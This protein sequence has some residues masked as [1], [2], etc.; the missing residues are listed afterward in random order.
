MHSMF[1]YFFASF[2]AWLARANL[3][4]QGVPAIPVCEPGT[5]LLRG[6]ASSTPCH[7]SYAASHLQRCTLWL[8]STSLFLEAWNK[9]VDNEAN[10]WWSLE[11]CLFAVGAWTIFL[12]TQRRRLG[13]PQL[14][15]YMLLGQTV[16]ISFAACLFNVALALRP[17]PEGSLVQTAALRS[18][19][20]D[21]ALPGQVLEVQEEVITEEA[22][23][24]D[25]TASGVV[26]SQTVKRKTTSQYII[27]AP[28][29]HPSLAS[30]LLLWSLTL[31]AAV[32]LK[33]RP[34][35]TLSVAI[36][37]LLPLA[38]TL[39]H[40]WLHRLEENIEHRLLR[41]KAGDEDEAGIHASNA[42]LQSILRPSSLLAVLAGWGF[43]MKAWTT[44]A[45]SRTLTTSVSAYDRVHLGR[46]T[47]LR[48]IIYPITF[49]SHPAQSSISSDAVCLALFTA[50]FIALDAYHLP[51][52]VARLG[53]PPS[54]ETRLQKKGPATTT[55]PARLSFT[56]HH[57]FA[58]WYAPSILLILMTPVLGPMTTFPA[59]LSLRERQLEK[60]ELEDE[61]R[62]RG[63]AGEGIGLVVKETREEI[64][65]TRPALKK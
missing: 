14:W 43:L 48:N 36:M 49:H 30:R 44:I 63:E 26:M 2:Q 65:S 60:A 16:A 35:T 64:V 54:E 24:E 57:L 15:A 45:L 22:Q 9:V 52:S 7:I 10:Y 38:L 8:S 50:L 6:L 47:L 42:R 61:R 1:R 51:K 56:Q 39:P 62:L 28:S 18:S 33:D 37:H 4:S 12:Q 32:S 31:L 3:T 53:T 27:E 29:T 20:A 34:T 13:V 19:S 55:I 58:G 41:P 25:G 46:A 11:V 21:E 5:S 40:Q 59:W 17:L 23:N